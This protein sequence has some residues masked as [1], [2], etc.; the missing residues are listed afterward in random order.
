[1]IQDISPHKLDNA[2]YPDRTPTPDDFIIVYNDRQILVK[3]NEEEKTM[4]FPKLSDVTKNNEF[5]YLFSIDETGFYMLS[6]Y[7]QEAFSDGTLPHKKLLDKGFV[8]MTVR[9]LTSHPLEPQIYAYA[10][11]TAMHLS[12]WYNRHQFCGRCG[13]ILR[14]DNVE[15]A[16]KCNNCGQIFYPRLN[17]AVIVGVKNGDK[18]LLTRYK[19][20]YRYNAL[21]AGFVEIGETVE[22]AVAREVKE[23][24]GLSVKN[25]KYYKSQPW[26]I[27][28]DLLTGFYCDVDGDDTI[29][30]DEGELKY[31]QWVKREDI[32]LQP[33]EYSLTNE[34]MKRF[35][36]GCVL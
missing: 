26:G 17:P 20:G 22:E 15:R 16:M 11:F 12:E 10:A 30:M 8:F 14:R 18:I 4:T 25:I 9:S 29:H 13:S 5:V 34:M 3:V 33:T 32:E 28:G 7:R 23:E 19:Q 21:V 6:E 1:M 27:A 31:A 35:K 2:Y 24:T 36:E